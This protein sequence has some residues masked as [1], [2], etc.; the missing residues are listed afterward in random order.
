MTAYTLLFA[1]CAAS[2]VSHEVKW[3]PTVEETPHA[4]GWEDPRP[5]VLMYGGPSC[6]I[7]EAVWDEYRRTETPYRIE[8]RTPLPWMRYVP[9]FYVESPRSESGWYRWQ[10]VHNREGETRLEYVTRR[11]RELGGDDWSICL[12]SLAPPPRVDGDGYPLNPQGWDFGALG[13]DPSV[14]AMVRHLS[15]APHY[16]EEDWLRTLTE[17]ELESLHDDDHENR[18]KQPAQDHKRRPVASTR[19]LNLCPT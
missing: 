6:A 11:W 16:F 8:K 5:V 10:G 13:W 15:G 18:L 7:C 12:A 17:R 9:W 1:V 4:I 3:A 19:R 2:P 14:E